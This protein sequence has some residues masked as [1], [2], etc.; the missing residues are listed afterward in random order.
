VTR[1]SSPGGGWWT[2]AVDAGLIGLWHRVGDDRGK[3]DDPLAG[4]VIGRRHGQAHRRDDERLESIRARLRLSIRSMKAYLADP[5]GN[6]AV[7]ADFECAEE[8][9]ICRWCNFRAV[10]R[11]EL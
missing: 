4:R 3:L 10:C 5:D 6:I 2:A 8:L 7:M 9:R 1:A 11:P